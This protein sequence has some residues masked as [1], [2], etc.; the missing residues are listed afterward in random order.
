MRRRRGGGESL[1]ISEREGELGSWGIDKRLEREVRGRFSQ[2]SISCLLSDI[3]IVIW[4][5]HSLDGQHRFFF[6][7]ETVFRGTLFHLSSDLY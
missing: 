7:L 3:F 1:F 4:I 6:S 2:S 5:L